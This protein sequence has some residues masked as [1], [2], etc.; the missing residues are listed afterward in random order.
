MLSF[1]TE[2]IS[3]HITRIY[4]FN[5]ESMYF[6]KGDK[7]GVLIDTGSGFGHLR[8]VVD[9]LTDLPYFV[10]LTHG[11]TDHAMGAREFSDL[12]IYM[13]HADDEVFAYHGDRDFRWRQMEMSEVYKDLTEDDYVPTPDSDTFLDLKEGDTFDLGGIH[14]DVYDCPGHTRGCKVLLI[15]EERILILGDACNG[16]TFLFDRFS[17]GVATYKK[18][19]E[20]LKDKTDGLYDEIYLFHTGGEPYKD[21]ITS[22]IEV[23][24]DILLQRN[25]A[26]QPFDFNGQKG[27]LAKAFSFEKGRLD[28]GH[29]N[30]VYSDETLNRVD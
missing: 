16:L 29:A 30:I 27:K 2:E 4:A 15:R 6:V 14:I 20:I 3:E 18:S 24:E 12:D 22:A 7:K 1:Q 19:L 25:V 13:D 11:H 21:M 10:L 28:G 23:C 26:N 17:T 8:P 5:T 9:S